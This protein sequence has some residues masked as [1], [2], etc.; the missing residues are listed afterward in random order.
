MCHANAR[1]GMGIKH[2][3]LMDKAKDLNSNYVDNASRAHAGKYKELT[4]VGNAKFW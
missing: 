1:E 3:F 4:T 2:Q